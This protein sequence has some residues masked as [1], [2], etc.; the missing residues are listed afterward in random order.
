MRQIAEP[1][2]ITIRAEDSGEDVA[3]AFNYQYHLISA[4]VVDKAGRMV[5]VIT[6]DERH[7]RPEH[8]ERGGHAAAGRRQRRGQGHRYGAGDR[9]RAHP[10]LAVNLCTAILPPR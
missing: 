3:Y 2:F 7:V 6:I 9:A 8:R 10:W 5:G 4:P 1:T